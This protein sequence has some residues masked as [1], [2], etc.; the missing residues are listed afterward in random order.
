MHRVLRERTLQCGMMRLYFPVQ[1]LDTAQCIEIRGSAARNNWAVYGGTGWIGLEIFWRCKG[2]VLV[3]FQICRDEFLQSVELFC[4]REGQVLAGF[5]WRCEAEGCFAKF[6]HRRER[7]RR[8]VTYQDQFLLSRV[9]S[10]LPEYFIQGCLY[11]NMARS[12]NVMQ[13]SSLI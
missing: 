1:I 2:Q 7:R 3:G 5:R 12:R 10:I 11:V 6:V 9:I 4:Y 13:D 8:K